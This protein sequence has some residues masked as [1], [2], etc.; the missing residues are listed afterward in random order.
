VRC[1]AAVQ[2]LFLFHSF[3]PLNHRG[4]PRA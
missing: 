3:T 2:I 1:L 4:P